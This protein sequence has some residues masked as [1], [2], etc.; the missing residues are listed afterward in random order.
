[1]KRIIAIVVL[2]AMALNCA[3]THILSQYKYTVYRQENVV[4]VSEQ[5]GEA[6]DV[7]EGQR[8]GLFTAI[9]GFKNARVYAITRGGFVIEIETE[10]EKL[11]AINGDPD[12]VMML[13]EYM[14]NYDKISTDPKIFENKWG[15]FDYDTLGIP[16]TETEV[17]DGV[18]QSHAHA[19]KGCAQCCAVSTVFSLLAG[20][21]VMGMGATS[22]STD[23]GPAL[24]AVAGLGVLGASSLLGVIAAVSP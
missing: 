6:I 22:G 24:T 1:M 20:M 8:F 3:S 5:V 15:I 16:I 13:G 11:V 21:V 10:S 2:V 14:D 4:I 19:R 17:N 12:M 9:K 18:E 7:E 23:I